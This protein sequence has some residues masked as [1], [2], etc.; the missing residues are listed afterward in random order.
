MQS[1]LECC[2]V[3]NS[4]GPATTVVAAGPAA[5]S[6]SAASGGGWS[7][8]RPSSIG[9]AS[10]SG[11]PLRREA[12]GEVSRFEADSAASQTGGPAIAPG[13]AAATVAL[14]TS[15]ESQAGG[16]HA[17]PKEKQ[18]WPGPELASQSAKDQARPKELDFLKGGGRVQF[19][20]DQQPPL[21]PTSERGDAQTKL[22][23]G[24]D[25][26]SEIT[27]SKSLGE[28]TLNSSFLSKSNNSLDSGQ[29]RAL[30]SLGR[31]RSSL[32]GGRSMSNLSSL[33]RSSSTLAEAVVQTGDRLAEASD[34]RSRPVKRLLTW[35]GRQPRMSWL[36]SNAP[37]SKLE[38]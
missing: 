33:G 3:C 29:G 14:A 6:S 13:D 28:L 30:S 11:T 8:G 38:D 16:G 34:S 21:S 2:T 5:S 17:S 19:D 27:G 31:S 25:L 20:G 32:E 12:N 36:A 4:S 23:R 7:T 26:R 18:R 15:T 22:F 10:G 35:P 24:E 1:V 37:L 9:N